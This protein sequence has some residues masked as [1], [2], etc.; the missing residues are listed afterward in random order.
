METIPDSNVEQHLRDIALESRRTS[1]R[2][3]DERGINRA[4]GRLFSDTIN[5]HRKRRTATTKETMW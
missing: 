3:D 2:G 1:E 4:D 5:D